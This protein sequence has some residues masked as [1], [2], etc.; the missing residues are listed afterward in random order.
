MSSFRK[1]KMRLKLSRRLANKIKASNTPSHLR[2]IFSMGLMVFVRNSMWWPVNDRKSNAA[3]PL[4]SNASTSN[5]SQQNKISA[6][7]LPVL[8]FD[9]SSS[10]MDLEHKIVGEV[11]WSSLMETTWRENRSLRKIISPPSSR[12]NLMPF[13]PK[14]SELRSRH[15]VIFFQQQFRH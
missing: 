13:S 15:S 5:V 3:P 11:V 8:T 4:Q 10:I 9:L 12:R 2:T 1:N 7:S 14:S 6:D